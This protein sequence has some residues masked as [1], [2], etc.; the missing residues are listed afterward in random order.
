ML[1]NRW[2][3]LAFLPGDFLSLEPFR[4]LDHGEFNRLALFQSAIAICL[5]RRMVNEYITTRRPLDETI[6]L[7]IVEPLYSTSL[8]T[9]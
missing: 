1:V 8:S 5:D 3:G 4:T 6:A 9:H 2:F 7:R